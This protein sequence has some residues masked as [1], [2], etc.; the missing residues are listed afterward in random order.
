MKRQESLARN[1]LTIYVST[2]S[3]PETRRSN[4]RARLPVLLRIHAHVKSKEV[5]LERLEQ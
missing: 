4:T 1:L 3:R 2:P 5:L